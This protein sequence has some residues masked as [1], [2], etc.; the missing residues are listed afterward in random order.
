MGYGMPE[1]V[2]PRIGSMLL[3]RTD[4]RG[5]VR[6]RRTGNESVPDVVH[7]ENRSLAMQAICSG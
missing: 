5:L 4:P 3:A 6:P 2:L 7:E 1:K